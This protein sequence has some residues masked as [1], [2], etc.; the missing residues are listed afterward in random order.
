MNISNISFQPRNISFKSNSE[1]AKPKEV[2][3]K[4]TS[5]PEVVQEK[6][7]SFKKFI[8]WAKKGN[9]TIKNTFSNFSKI[10]K[11]AI[12]VEEYGKGAISGTIGGMVL[13][14]AIMGVDWLALKGIG[15]GDASQKI[16]IHPFKVAGGV[17]KTIAK[18]AIKIPKKTVG[19]CITYPFTKAPKQIYEYVKNA[20][21]VSKFGKALAATVGIGT[22]GLSLLRSTVRY[23][24]RTADI[25][26]AFYQGHRKV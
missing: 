19:E 16:L 10:Y 12:G 25:D 13:G 17:L 14:G 21:G 5:A 11:V 23:N 7:G 22:L 9:A 24:V 1:A 2:T 15:K 18:K 6:E 8:D 20:K 4:T 3:T 26:H